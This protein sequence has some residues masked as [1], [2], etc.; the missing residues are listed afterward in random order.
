M[1]AWAKAV[2]SIR[3][4][5]DRDSPARRSITCTRCNEIRYAPWESLIYLWNP[6]RE[7]TEEDGELIRRMALAEHAKYGHPVEADYR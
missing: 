5:F 4:M 1:S 2:R 6:N 7:W 3:F